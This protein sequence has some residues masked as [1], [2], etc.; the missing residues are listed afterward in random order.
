MNISRGLI[1]LASVIDVFC[2]ASATE[3]MISSLLI[4][5]FSQFLN[6]FISLTSLYLSGHPVVPREMAPFPCQ[7]DTKLHSNQINIQTV[8][9]EKIPYR[10]PH[11]NNSYQNSKNP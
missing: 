7:Q 2:K 4:D 10:M 9:E 11:K 8:D 6:D 5:F 1:S 3:A